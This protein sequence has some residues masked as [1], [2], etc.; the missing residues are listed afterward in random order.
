MNQWDELF[1]IAN[2]IQ[3]SE[4]EDAI[5][6]QFNSPGRYLVQSLYTVIN[7]KGVKQIYTP[8][9]WKIH[10]PSRIHIFLW[11]LVNNK[12][13]ITYNLAKRRQVKDKNLSFLH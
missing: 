4:E 8:V 13:L 6:W 2:N 9:I 11:L 7:D 3:F 5:I 12:V 10:V 1:Q